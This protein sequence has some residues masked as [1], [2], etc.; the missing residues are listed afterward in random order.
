MDTT[1]HRSPAG[2][3]PRRVDQLLAHYGESHTEPRN[4]AIHFVAIP[5]IMLSLVG[6]MFAVHPWLAYAFVAASLVYYARL[7][8]VFL[9]A[10]AVVSAAILGLVHAMGERVLPVSAGIFVAAWVAQFIGH[11][12]Q[13]KKPS[14]FEDL[15]Y[16]WVGPLFVL[17]KAFAPLG[18]RW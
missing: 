2:S 7:S 5:L 12:L 18:I 13:G 11:K 17:S 4:E 1:A 10:M 8:A 14:F 6:L 3:A 16:L 15:Q 9:V